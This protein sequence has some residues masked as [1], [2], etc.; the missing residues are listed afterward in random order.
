MAL[1]EDPELTI[2]P[3]QLEQITS[4]FLKKYK[5]KPAQKLSDSKAQ[6]KKKK[7]HSAPSKTGRFLPRA[8]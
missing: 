5:V 4:E 7:S 6:K 2:S 8:K 1:P 3:G